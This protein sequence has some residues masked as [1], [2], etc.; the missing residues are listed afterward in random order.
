MSDKKEVL[1]RL[2]HQ[3]YQ[4]LQDVS[5]KE[6]RA[7]SQ[8]IRQACQQYVASMNNKRVNM[9]E[10]ALI[11]VDNNLRPDWYVGLHP[12]GLQSIVNDLHPL[13]RRIHM[14]RRRDPSIQPIC[15]AK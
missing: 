2:D 5:D 4:D 6:D 13:M 3:L 11:W 9:A 14:L 8:I 7:L 15:G 12:D 1:L 10:E